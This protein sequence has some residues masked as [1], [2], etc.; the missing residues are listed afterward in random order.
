MVTKKKIGKN[1]PI[2]VI[3]DA[4]NAALKF[5]VIMY[6]G[7][8]Y[9]MR[10]FL[11]PHAYIQL[12]GAEWNKKM[13][14]ATQGGR[15]VGG[16][17]T[18]LHYARNGDFPVMIGRGAAQ[19]PDNIPFVAG[20]KY[21]PH[22]LPALFLAGLLQVLPRSEFPTGSTRILLGCGIPPS[23]LQAT[24]MV[25]ELLHGEHNITTVDGV[26]MKFKVK[27][28]NLFSENAGGMVAAMARADKNG[29]L[30]NSAGE[31]VSVRPGDSF[32]FADGGGRIGSFTAGHINADGLA[33]INEQRGF[34]SV[35]GGIVPIRRRLKEALKELHAHAL[36]EITDDMMTDDWL[37]SV[38]ETKQMQLHGQKPI[39]VSEAVDDAVR[40]YLAKLKQ[41]YTDIGGALAT[42]MFVTG[43]GMRTLLPYV[44][45]VVE[46]DSIIPS[47]N[48][49]SLIFANALGGLPIVT[50]SFDE[51]GILPAEFKQM[52]KERSS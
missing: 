21:V 28:V 49:D 52:L 47:A 36:R 30:R 7:G 10:Q 12:T 18:F 27:A 11:I 46:R 17:S 29:K 32:V 23:Q 35:E 8:E 3:V 24:E 31:Y 45:R 38:L 43:G 26:D 2:L 25:A 34:T 1:F 40:P 14:K 50:A 4:G 37:D 20:A 15:T 19:S 41:G 13:R 39:D 42:L 33:E 48:L 22:G 16:T 6:V 9:V 5:I 44:F 51:A